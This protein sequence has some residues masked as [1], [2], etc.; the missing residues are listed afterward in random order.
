[1][2]QVLSD[3][4]QNMSEETNDLTTL[5]DALRKIR[6]EGGIGY[7]DLG[8]Q[9]G[10]AGHTVYRLLNYENPRFYDT[11]LYKIRE[12]VRAHRAKPRRR[13]PQGEQRATP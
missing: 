10:V 4:T 3:Q 12:F 1:M 5:K 11:T 9:I 6:L 13:R 8:E 2:L 7:D